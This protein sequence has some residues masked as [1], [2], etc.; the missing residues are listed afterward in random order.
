M[1]FSV[2]GIGRRR[3]NDKS[4]ATHF[5]LNILMSFSELDYIRVSDMSVCV[6]T[7][8]MRHINLRTK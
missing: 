5:S 6:S 7:K 8:M 2:F 3:E 4:T 1:N